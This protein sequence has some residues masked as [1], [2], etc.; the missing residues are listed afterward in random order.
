MGRWLA[1][2]AV[3]ADVTQTRSILP[4]A[5]TIEEFVRRRT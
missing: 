5:A 3:E 4:D 2:H 1:S